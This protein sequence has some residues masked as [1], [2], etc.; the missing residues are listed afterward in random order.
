MHER[1]TFTGKAC[2]PCEFSAIWPGTASFN[3][4]HLRSIRSSASG[5]RWNRRVQLTFMI[6]WDTV[7]AFDL[8]AC[9]CQMDNFHIPFTGMAWHGIAMALHCIALHS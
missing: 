6:D 4:I 1:R 5:R 2:Q 9:I 7:I 3:G 8:I